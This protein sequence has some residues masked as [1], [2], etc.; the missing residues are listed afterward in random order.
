MLPTP[1]TPHVDSLPVYP[2]SEDSFLLLDTLEAQREYLTSRFPSG[3]GPVVLEA[4]TGSGVVVAFLA[5]HSSKIFGHRNVTLL[6]VDMNPFACRAARTTVDLAVTVSKGSSGRY[7][8]A[9]VGDLTDAVR[10]GSIDVLVFNP[11][12]VPSEGLPE[13][14]LFQSL[15]GVNDKADFET[16]SRFLDL[17]VSGGLDGMISTWKLLNQLKHVLSD[18]GTAYVLLCARNKPDKVLGQLRSQGWVVDKVG[19]SGKKGGIEKLCII[20][21]SR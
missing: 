3:S 4:G 9:F 1:E 18:S 5:A 6:A 14:V 13:P 11:P 8:G 2:P 15:P 12:Y 19:S 16:E 10:P 21:I 20:R 7:L 17:A